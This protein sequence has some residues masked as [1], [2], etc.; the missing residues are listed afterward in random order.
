M[1]SQEKTSES[2][3]DKF[4]AYLEKNGVI[5]KLTEV[6]VSLYGEVDKPINPL[7]YIKHN[8]GDLEEKDQDNLKNENL[9]LK[10][11]NEKFKKQIAELQ[12]ENEPLKGD[13]AN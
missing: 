13:T 2:E 7:E 4:R 8:L 3:K 1:A 9:K 12:K 5:E 6:F 11:E 10:Q